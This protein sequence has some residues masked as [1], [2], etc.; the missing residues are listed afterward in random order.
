M[1]GRAASIDTNTGIHEVIITPPPTF[2]GF[3]M[4]ENT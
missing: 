4:K 1:A 2:L 3:E